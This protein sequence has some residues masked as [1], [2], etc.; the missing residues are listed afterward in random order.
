[1]VKKKRKKKA[2]R[3]DTKVYQAKLFRKQANKAM[4]L[5]L[6]AVRKVGKNQC[7]ICG[8]KQGEKVNGKPVRLNCHH[9][10]DRNN[11]A[12]RFDIYNGVLLCP[13]HHKF[14]ID[15]AHKAPVWFL[16]KLSNRIVEYLIAIRTEL[17]QRRA[18][19]TIG[20]LDAVIERLERIN[21]A[22]AIKD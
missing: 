18:G 5:W 11:W 20:R 8:I 15:S 16:T 7:F 12:L 21:N 9:I 19:W 22:G 10:E 17:P 2:R 13:T 1:M 3:T 6:A 4:K 14:G